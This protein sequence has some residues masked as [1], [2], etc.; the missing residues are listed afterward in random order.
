MNLPAYLELDLPEITAWLPE[1]DLLA[2][3]VNDAWIEREQALR[4]KPGQDRGCPFPVSERFEL[5]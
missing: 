4:Y 3:E 5:L 1:H 2:P